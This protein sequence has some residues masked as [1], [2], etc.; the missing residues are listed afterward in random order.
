MESKCKDTYFTS[1][2]A[3]YSELC[4]SECV[5]FFFFPSKEFFLNLSAHL[6]LILTVGTVQ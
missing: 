3:V 5:A 4:V 2:L 6:L 1:Y